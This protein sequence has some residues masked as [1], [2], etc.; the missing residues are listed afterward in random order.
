MRCGC[1]IALVGHVCRRVVEA[2]RFRNG[3]GAGVTRTCLDTPPERSVLASQRE[4]GVSGKAGSSA[5][6]VKLASE[7]SVPRANGKDLQ[8]LHSRR[9]VLRTHGAATLVH[10]L[11]ARR[12][13]NND[14]HRVTG[15]GLIGHIPAPANRE[16]EHTH[17][18]QYVH[19]SRETR[20]RPHPLADSACLS[21]IHW[22]RTLLP[23]T[24]S[25]YAVERP[26]EVR[27]HG[28]AS[29]VGSIS[30]TRSMRLPR[31]HRRRRVQE[32]R[33]RIGS[34]R[35]HGAMP[36]ARST[37]RQVRDTHSPLTKDR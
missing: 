15:L 9:G 14:A 29:D 35:Q 31:G 10:L 17:S 1:V 4:D 18:M 33:T 13:G 7:L 25:S 23:F 21:S 24:I 32:S 20:R 36:T 19:V 2:G 27:K 12:T 5:F 16:M 8:F 34:H 37:H 28:D 30:M 6:H 22:A 11:R 3:A 26:G